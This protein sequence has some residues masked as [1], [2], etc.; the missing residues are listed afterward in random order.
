MSS[1]QYRKS[2]CGDKTVVRSSYL[3]NW[4]SYTGK[5]AS[6]YW[7]RALI[8]H[9]YEWP[10]SSVCHFFLAPCSYLSGQV[11]DHAFILMQSCLESTQSYFA[12]EFAKQYL[13]DITV[14]VSNRCQCCCQKF[15]FSKGYYIILL[16]DFLKIRRCCVLWRYNGNRQC[17]WASTTRIP[18]FVG[19]SSH[20]T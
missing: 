17:H 20:M 6:L 8:M 7:I 18:F 11:H 16:Q 15:L 5:M 4:I 10:I 14:I 3:H 2:H 19:I 13:K 12:F 9:R 1:Y